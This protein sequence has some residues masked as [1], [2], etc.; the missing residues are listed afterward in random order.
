M[1]DLEAVIAILIQSGWE[2]H[3][4]T[5]TQVYRVGTA[6]CPVYRGIGGQVKNSGGRMRF[7]KGNRRCTVGARTT[8]F[9][10]LDEQ[11][12]ICESVNLKTNHIQ[13]IRTNAEKS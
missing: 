2:S 11:K 12:R 10:R 4:Q 9:Y 13:E 8:C 6:D 5:E 7:R 1:A 3:G